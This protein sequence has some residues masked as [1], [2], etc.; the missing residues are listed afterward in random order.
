MFGLPT[1]CWERIWKRETGRPTE[2]ER[3]RLRETRE[4]GIR[5]VEFLATGETRKAA[6][7]LTDSR[8]KRKAVRR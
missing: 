8:L 7:I 2:S 5:K 6:L 3:Q 4:G 1:E